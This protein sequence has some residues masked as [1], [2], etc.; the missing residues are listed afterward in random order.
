MT[1]LQSLLGRDWIEH[2]IPHQGSMCLLE[3]VQRWSDAEI[4]CLAHSHRALD[5]P[6][7]NARGLPISAGIE[8]A[9]QAMAVHGALLASSDQPPQVGFLTSVRNVQWWTPRLDDVGAELSIQAIRISGNAVSLLYDFSI[10]CDNRLLLQG[11]AG[12]MTQAPAASLQ[13]PLASNA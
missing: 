4:L 10:H 13:T 7:R 8:Y 3:S 12:V 9:A 11:R 6:L 1:A 2:H 5:N